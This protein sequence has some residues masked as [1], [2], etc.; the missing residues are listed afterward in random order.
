[1]PTL[2][3]VVPGTPAPQGSKT[4]MAHGGM[5]ESSK[6]VRPWREAVRH[7]AYD[8]AQAQ[9][10]TPPLAV[11]VTVTFTMARPALHYGTGRNAARLKD[12]APGYPTGR[13]DLDKLARSTLDAL[14]D[15]GAIT[16]D[17]RVVRLE[18][19]K[20]FPGRHLDALDTPGAV[21]VVTAL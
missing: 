7:E 3:V 13:P 17:A 1:V 12:T 10:W 4:R 9:A 2:V 8:A 11:A 6:A 16:D 14:T 15:A 18:A 5:V 19:E 20:C 21:I